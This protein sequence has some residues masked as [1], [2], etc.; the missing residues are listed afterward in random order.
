MVDQL[1]GPFTT[2]AKQLAVQKEVKAN[3]ETYFAKAAISRMWFPDRLIE[4]NQ[5]AE[6]GSLVS[7]RTKE[8]LL[9]FLGVESVVDDYVFSGINGAGDSVA[10]RE[11]YMQWGFEERRHDRPFGIRL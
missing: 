11:L 7:E 4:R 6:Y 9:G 10:T 8:I 1:T 5:M 3:Y 2:E